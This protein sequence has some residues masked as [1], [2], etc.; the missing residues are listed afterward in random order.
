M[1]NKQC[2]HCKHCGWPMDFDIRDRGA[3][4]RCLKCETLHT[5]HELL[6]QVLDRKRKDLRRW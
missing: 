1:D 6:V 2:G 4:F 5:H 3:E